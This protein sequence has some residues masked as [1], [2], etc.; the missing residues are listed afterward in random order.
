MH[1]SISMVHARAF[2][3][4]DDST[5]VAYPSLPAIVGPGIAGNSMNGPQ[6][7]ETALILF[8]LRYTQSAWYQE[9]FQSSREP[10]QNAS[11]YMWQTCPRIARMVRVISGYSASWLSMTSSIW[12]CTTATSTVLPLRVECEQYPN[13]ARL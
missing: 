7:L 12:N 4:T 11:S 5:S 2:S 10:M 1:R 3:F 8:Q 13:M 6:P 9:L